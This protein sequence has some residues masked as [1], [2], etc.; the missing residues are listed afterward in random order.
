ML[1]NRKPSVNIFI[2]D[3][4]QLIL[5]I[6]TSKFRTATSYNVFAFNCGEDLLEHFIKNPN[7]KKNINV[8][9]LD[10]LLSV[11]GTKKN[12]IDILKAIKEH[13][14][15]IEVLMLSGKGDVDTAISA[16]HHGALTFVEKSENSFARINNNIQMIVSEKSLKFVKKQSLMSTK[17]FLILL[18]S[19][20]VVLLMLWFIFPQI[21]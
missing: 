16:M 17:I 20:V 4:D 19:A 14:P 21:F 2:V 13:N 11:D 5:N 3:D 15:T 12:G 1:S 8:V 9:V 18:F 6:F 10:Y 7:I